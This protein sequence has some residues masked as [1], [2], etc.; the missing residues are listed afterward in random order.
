MVRPGPARPQTDGVVATRR[1]DRRHRLVVI[2]PDIR[3]QRLTGERDT[4]ELRAVAPATVLSGK[5][6]IVGI[7]ATDFS[8]NSGRSELRLASEAVLD[9]LDDAGL[10]PGDVDGMVTFT[11]DSNTEIS[12]ARATA[13]E[14]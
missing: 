12:I 2:V 10:T 14:S 4:G 7:G 13:S 9:A 3:A 11:M 5:A 6:A 8:K 1:D